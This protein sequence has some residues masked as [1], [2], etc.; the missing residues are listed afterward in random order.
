MWKVTLYIAI[1]CIKVQV[2]FFQYK[3]KCDTYVML[4]KMYDS[5]VTY[6]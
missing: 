1:I 2:K 3:Y 5:F 6:R 4:K